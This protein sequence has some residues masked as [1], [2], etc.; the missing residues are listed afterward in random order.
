MQASGWTLM[1][2]W[3]Y[4]ATFHLVV[5][6]GFPAWAHVLL[7]L[8]TVGV[9]LPFMILINATT[10]GGKQQWCRLTFDDSGQPKYETIKRPMA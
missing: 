5:P 4:G 9:W 6:G 7:I 10:N 8:L 1:Q 3:Q 2:R